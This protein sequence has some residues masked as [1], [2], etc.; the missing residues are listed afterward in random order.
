MKDVDL[1]YYFMYGLYL[2]PLIFTIIKI[3]PYSSFFTIKLSY[4]LLVTA[5][6]T[7]VS[8][9][10]HHIYLLTFSENIVGMKKLQ[11][12]FTLLYLP[13]IWAIL[14]SIFIYKGLKTDAREYA[15]AG[16]AL[17]GVTIVK[18]YL[19]D[20]W[21]MDNVRDDAINYPGLNL[22][23]SSFLFQRLKNIVVTMV[24]KK[25]EPDKTTWKWFIFNDLIKLL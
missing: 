1:K 11:E 14:A 24:E 4:W 20:A 10:T 19:Y 25:E 22:K 13:I 8:M 21:K 3:I 18:L 7:A 5:V 2:I 15:K 6:V 16:F 17:L 12:Y 23:S 9:E